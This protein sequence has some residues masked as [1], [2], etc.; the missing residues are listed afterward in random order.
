MSV[1]LRD[2][3]LYLAQNDNLRNFVVTNRMTRGVSRRFV[4]GEAL[5]EA[6]QA[7][8]VLNQRGMHVSLDHLGENVSDAQEAVSSTQDFIL[9]LI[10]I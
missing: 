2:T 10:H 6:V 1:I 3:L 4:A 5:D 9:S 7:T 8:R